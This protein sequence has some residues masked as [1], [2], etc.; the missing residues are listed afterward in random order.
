[1]GLLRYEVKPNMRTLGAKFGPRLKE[2]Q[3]ALAGAD[4]TAIAAKV[5]A[6]QPFE[7][8]CHGGSVTLE[9]ADVGVQTRA[10]EGWTGAEERGTQVAL[11]ARVTE[12]LAREGMAREVVR[13]VQ[14]ARKDAGLEMEDRIVLHLHTDAEKLK[15]AVAVYRAYLAGE[16]LVGEW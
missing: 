10:E 5:R 1:N 6:G 14:Q 2:V 16:T 13:H 12:E 3:A 11:D 15:K 9:P 4:A 7:L 8:A